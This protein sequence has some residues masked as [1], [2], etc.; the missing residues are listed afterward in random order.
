MTDDLVK[1]LRAWSEHETTW[2]L[3]WEAAERIKEQDRM[4]VTTGKI[5][6]QLVE[7]T[8][9]QIGRIWELEAALR[10]IAYTHIPDQPAAAYGDGEYWA[11]EQHTELR[12]I[13]LAA[14]GKKKDV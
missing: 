13:A 3:L 7:H 14:L 9:K 12:R 4:I 1:R 8:T 5:N 6:I 2:D 11:R 10:K